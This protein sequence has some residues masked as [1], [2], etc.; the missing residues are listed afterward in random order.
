M[1][2]QHTAHGGRRCSFG[3]STLPYRAHFL[4]SERGLDSGSGHGLFPHHRT[5]PLDVGPSED[6]GRRRSALERDFHFPCE[7]S[8]ISIVTNGMNLSNPY[9]DTRESNDHPTKRQRT[10]R[11]KGLRT[12]AGCSNCRIR[13][14]KCSEDK[15]KCVACE[16]RGEGCVYQHDLPV[17]SQSNDSTDSAATLRHPR[18]TTG[19]NRN[20][21][22][23]RHSASSILDGP[24]STADQH[25]LQHGETVAS[26]RQVTQDDGRITQVDASNQT[27][28]PDLTPTSNASYIWTASPE[29]AW[30]NVALHSAETAS[31]LWL[32][33]LSNDAGSGNTEEPNPLR[34]L[35]SQTHSPSTDCA[36]AV[37]QESVEDGTTGIGDIAARDGI[38]L[39]EDIVLKPDEVAL[40]RHF[41]DVVST[42]IDLTDPERSFA[43]RVSSMALRDQGLM[44]A[45]LA[46]SARHISV[47]P[48]LTQ[49]NHHFSS[50]GTLGVK[51]Y[52][53]TLQY[54]QRAMQHPSYLRSDQLLATV[55]LI[56]TYEMLDTNGRDWE[57]HLKGVF[58]IQRSQLIHGESA[59]FK[60]VIW[61]AWLRQDIWAAYKDRRKILS[62]YHLKRPCAELGFWE[63]VNYS[64]FL[65]GQC[66]NYASDREVQ[67]GVSD[68]Q[69]R[70][71][72]GQRLWSSLEEWA[73]HFERYDRRL[74][75]VCNDDSPF[76]PIWIN[77]PAASLAIQ[78]HNLAKLLL[79]DLMPALSGLAELSKRRANVR[80]CVAVICGIAYCTT[81]SAP[82]ITSTQCLYAARPHLTSQKEIEALN[83]LLI[84][85]Q[86]QTGWPN[87]DLGVDVRVGEISAAETTR[88]LM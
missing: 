38:D 69:A 41:V 17:S 54:L 73:T 83:S 58:W 7:T 56:S 26:P 2:H 74:P 76:P 20:Q 13:R 39:E 53:Q 36:T 79:S 35:F 12:R 65:L 86:E 48:L 71:A 15:P 72:R 24:P 18:T 75:T 64:V 51:Y 37:F 40:L 14:V 55:L 31:L 28:P 87:H 77:P 78:V 32:G 44:R 61:W 23:N 68:V 70:I 66:V 42:W 84:S 60:Q 45:I 50:A 6:T 33:L 4:T 82:M 85:H 19:D 8:S 30:S 63:L 88:P 47:C 21:D 43:V 49:M 29:S 16:R 81:E 57:Q 34:D 1:R 10:S 46:L 67:D 62:F 25:D 9:R 27:F 52:H 3:Y 22:E 80:S 5:T 11:G 59:G